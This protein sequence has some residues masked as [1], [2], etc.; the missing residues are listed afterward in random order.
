MSR[1]M[2]RAILPSEPV[3]QTVAMSVP[4]SIRKSEAKFICQRA[5]DRESSVPERC[6]GTA[7]AAKLHD[8]SFRKRIVETLMTAADRTQPTRRF[9]PKRSRW[10]GL[11]ERPT[12][13]HGGTMFRRQPLQPMFQSGKVG[14]ENELRPL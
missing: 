10:C 7:R 11:H 14:I 6:Q 9:E 13:H 8:Q 12:K 3:S 2:S 4:G 5:T 1:L